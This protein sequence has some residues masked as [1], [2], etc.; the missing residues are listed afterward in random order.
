MEPDQREILVDPD[1]AASRL[2]AAYPNAKVLMVIREQAEWL[3]SAYKYSINELPAG[4][5]SFADY[6]ETPYGNVLLQAGHYDET[7]RAYIDIFG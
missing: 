2:H 6:C 5:R 3:N 1:E 7:I 4:Q